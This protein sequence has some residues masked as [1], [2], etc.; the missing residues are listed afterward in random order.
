M[1]LW[2][3]DLSTATAGEGVPIVQAEQDTPIG[4]PGAV[5]GIGISFAVAWVV[6][7]FVK[8]VTS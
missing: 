5:L 6:V 7:T 2:I 3:F 1:T 8:A 4:W